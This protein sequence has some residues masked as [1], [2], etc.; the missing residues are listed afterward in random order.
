FRQ[1]PQAFFQQPWIVGLFSALFVALALSMFGAYTLQMPAAI[2]TRLAAISN[3]QRSGTY[4]GCF[5]MGALSS[6]VATACVAPA[7]ISAVTVISQTREVAR[8][9]LALYATGIGMGVPLLVVGASAGSLLPKAGPWMDTI[10]KFFGV[11]FLGLAIY[12]L[13]PLIPA[14]ASMLLW[15]AL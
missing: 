15:S 6:L 3:Q 4:F 8:G 1:A 12:F 14:A 9:A 10:K 5:I 13:Q 11:V 2:Q 7:L